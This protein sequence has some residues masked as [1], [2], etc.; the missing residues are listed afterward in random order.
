VRGYRPEAID[1][2]GA[3][4]V[5]NPEWATTGEV[6]SLA[7]AEEHLAPGTLV[8]F[9]DIVLKRHIVQALLEEADAGITLAVDSALA[10]ADGPD[11]V[12]GDSAD[13][14]RFSCEAV[15]VVRIGERV[16]PGESHG[17]WIGMLHSGVDGA[18]WL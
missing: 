1:V 15:S 18:T 8:S 10:G 5:D 3:R 17:V 11:R 9:G 4:Y 16:A 14:G 7:L 12:L 2:P 6:W 13:S